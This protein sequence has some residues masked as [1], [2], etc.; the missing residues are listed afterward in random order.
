MGG[1]EEI[2]L[3]KVNLDVLLVVVDRDFLN[4]LESPRRCR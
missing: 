3:P 2:G 4:S 1:G